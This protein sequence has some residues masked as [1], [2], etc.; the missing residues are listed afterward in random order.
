MSRKNLGWKK[1][2]S[3]LAVSV[4]AENNISQKFSTG[5]VVPFPE[6]DLGKAAFISGVPAER[7]LLA[8][9]KKKLSGRRVGD[10]YLIKVVNLWHFAVSLETKKL[11]RKSPR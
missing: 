11:L 5:G 10:K 7:I 8:L 1:E 6:V 3:G 2:F 4:T 9:T